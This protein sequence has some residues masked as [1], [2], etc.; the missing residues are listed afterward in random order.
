MFGGGGGGGGSLKATVTTGAWLFGAD[1]LGDAFRRAIEKFTTNVT[2]L[3]DLNY[4]LREGLYRIGAGL[5]LPRVLGMAKIGSPAVRQL[6]GA[7]NIAAGL[8]AAT[9][10]YRETAYNAIGLSDYETVGE[11]E[12]GVMGDEGLTQEAGVLQLGDE[13]EEIL[14]DWET[15]GDYELVE[16][17]V[18]GGDEFTAS[19]SKYG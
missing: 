2:F 17:T 7:Q 10:V 12:Y 13:G 5:I 4:N 14:S 19:G 6:M 15:V 3:Q 18:A 16:E 11:G 9:R 8:I 1:L